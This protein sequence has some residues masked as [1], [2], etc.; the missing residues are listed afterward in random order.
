MFKLWLI[1]V[2]PLSLVAFALY[3]WDKRQ[4]KL[5]RWRVPEKTLH[6][7]SLFGGWPGA[8]LGQRVFRHKTQKKPF[9]IMFWLTAMANI[10][11]AVWFLFNPE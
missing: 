8:L 3:G 11:V 6:S 1:L 10:A 9:Q 2:V 5:D 7:V 4:A